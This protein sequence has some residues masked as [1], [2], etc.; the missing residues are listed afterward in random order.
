MVTLVLVGQNAVD[1]ELLTAL[2][3]IGLNRLHI[4]Y[5]SIA[6]LSDQAELIHQWFVG[7]HVQKT[8]LVRL[9][10][11]QKL[12]RTTG[13]WLVYFISIIFILV[14][15]IYLLYYRSPLRFYHWYLLLSECLF[16]S[17]LQRVI[18]VK[19]WLIIMLY[20]VKISRRSLTI[21]QNCW[22]LKVLVINLLNRKIIALISIIFTQF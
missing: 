11:I 5:M 21:L 9:M 2:L 3:A 16:L 15:Y 18:I 17:D 20:F 22:I 4:C 19:F 12:T 13:H 6:K 14:D 7:V 10:Q 1:A 8:V